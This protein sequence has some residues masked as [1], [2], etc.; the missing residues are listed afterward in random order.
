[1]LAKGTSAVMLPGLNPA[2]HNN[3][4]AFICP[5]S[6]LRIHGPATQFCT[7]ALSVTECLQ[8]TQK[9][10]GGVSEDMQ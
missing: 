5:L 8:G 10:T 9:E 1:M 3:M 7:I 6:N 2:N 4:L